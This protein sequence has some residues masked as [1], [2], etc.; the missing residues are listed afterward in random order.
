MPCYTV[1]CYVVKTDKRHEGGDWTCVPQALKKLRKIFAAIKSLTI[2]CSIITIVQ[3]MLQG[4]LKDLRLI[5]KCYI[6]FSPI[7]NSP[8]TKEFKTAHNFCDT[9]TEKMTLNLVVHNNNN[10]RRKYNSHCGASTSL[11]YVTLRW[12]YPQLRHVYKLQ[13]FNILSF[14]NQWAS[15]CK[16]GLKYLAREISGTRARTDLHGYRAGYP[17]FCAF[18]M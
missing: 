10:D 11:R 12:K 2:V 17:D 6:H 9:K 5:G 14:T 1:N 4:N 3:D 13:R 7:L 8:A 15:Y 16:P 18:V